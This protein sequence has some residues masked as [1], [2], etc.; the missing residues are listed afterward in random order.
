MALG[1]L[2]LHTSTNRLL[3]TAV[4]KEFAFFF[5]YSQQTTKQGELL[6]LQ[7]PPKR[8]AFL[9]ANQKYMGH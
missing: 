5:L 9:T 4:N 7:D 8:G 1:T 6:Q 2:L 3:L